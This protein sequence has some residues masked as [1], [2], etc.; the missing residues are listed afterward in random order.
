MKVYHGS[1]VKIIDIDLSKC[2]PH[3]DFGKGFYV[4][5]I[6]E[7]AAYWAERKGEDNGT[8][9][10]V[11][12]FEF[13]ET[14]FEH[15]N[16]KILR[17]NDYTEEWLDF[18]VMN[19]NRNLPV[20]AHDYDIVEG[21]VA[22][23]KVTQRIRFY[24]EGAVSKEAFLEELKFFKHTH[25]ICFCTRRSLQ[26][27]ELIYKKKF[28]GI[29]DDNIT[30]SLVASY[31]LSEREILDVYFESQTYKMLIDEST[32]LYKKSWTEVYQLLLSEL[33]LKK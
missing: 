22:D 11:T 10:F 12:E 7:Q 24:L 17:F 33:K 14:A 16:F 4:T 2:E 6:R 27:L 20:P 15:W 32:G 13:I 21:P 5:N 1:S 3:R 29:I 31:N 30:Q 18:I 19:R 28:T 9:G 23:D 8:K 25:Q 26:A